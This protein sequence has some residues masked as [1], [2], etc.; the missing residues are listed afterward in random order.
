MERGGRPV[1]RHGGAGWGQRD[2][3]DSQYL[4]KSHSRGYI[5]F[6]DACANL[7]PVPANSSQRFELRTRPFRSWQ[8]SGS[9]NPPQR[10]GRRVGGWPGV[11]VPR[12]PS[13]LSG[14]LDSAF[15]AQGC[16]PR[17]MAMHTCLRLG[18]ALVCVVYE[19]APLPFGIEDHSCAVNHVQFARQLVRIA[20]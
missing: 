16:L 5:L 10:R 3:R 7:G 8:P 2:C 18:V 13:A 19:D 14:S 4:G 17:T 6:D 11:D 12:Y 1:C 9:V 20:D 15:L